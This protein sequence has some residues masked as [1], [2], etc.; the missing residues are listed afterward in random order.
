MNINDPS[1]PSH[2]K[3]LSSLILENSKNGE[4]STLF[5]FQKTAYYKEA[6]SPEELKRF[7]DARPSLF[8]YTKSRQALQMSILC[9]V[10]DLFVPTYAP[11]QDAC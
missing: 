6:P 8:T 3:M 9:L 7:T 4:I 11:E 1:K 5:V 2:I 10:C